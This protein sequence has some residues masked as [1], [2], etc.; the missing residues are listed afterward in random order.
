MAAALLVSV[1]MVLV[2]C[3]RGAAAPAA[4]AAETTAAPAPE[5]KAPAAEP[6]PADAKPLAERRQAAMARGVA[7]IL[8]TQGADGSW[9][10]PKGS[11]GITALVVDGLLEA[12]QPATDPAVAKALDY[13]LKAQKEDG[14]IYDDVGLKIYASSISVLA[15]THA[16]AK[17]Y[18]EP[19]KKAMAFIEKS[20]WGADESIEKAD[21]NYGGFGY[22]KSNRPDMSN[23]Q[24]CLDAL[25]AAGVKED[26]PVW[27]RAVVFVSRCQDRSESNDKAFVGRDDGGGIYSPVESKAETITLPDGTKVM[28]TYGSMTYAVL[29]AFVFANLSPEDGRVKAA[30]DWVRKHWTFE[31]NPEMGQQGLYYYYM[32]AAR[33]LGAYSKAVKDDHVVDVRRR[34]HDWKAELSESILKRQKEDG[35]WTNEAD[36]WFEGYA[37]I[38]TSYALIALAQCR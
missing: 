36:R 20:Q 37:P 35:S 17:A 31:E 2:V 16:D 33:A 13:L 29:K 38:P 18:A 19:I 7:A 21:P 26:D 22:G 9:G 14:G 3:G 10:V 12:G 32:T 30:L 1:T 25:K 6:A 28:K 27:T 11:V 23:T 34:S 24:F 15:L 4:P 5:A 8:K